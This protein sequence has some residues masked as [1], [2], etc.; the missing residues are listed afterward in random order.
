MFNWWK[1]KSK[2]NKL[3][4]RVNSKIRLEPEKYFYADEGEEI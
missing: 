1:Q 4:G 2:T 3:Q